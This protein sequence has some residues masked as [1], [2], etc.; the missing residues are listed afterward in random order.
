MLSNIQEFHLAT[1]KQ[2]KD[3][4]PAPAVHI[5]PVDIVHDPAGH[6][7]TDNK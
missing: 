2:Y 1:Q 3:K 6:R 4:H 5:K 7:R